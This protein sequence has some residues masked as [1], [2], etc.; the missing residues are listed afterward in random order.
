M[1]LA[2]DVGGTTLRLTL[3]EPAHGPRRF[4]AKADYRSAEFS[5]LQPAIA[6]FLADT[7]AKPTSACFSV[8]G[9]VAGGRAHLTNLGWE[10]DGAALARDCGLSRVDIVNDVACM[11][12]SLPHLQP[13]EFVTLNRGAAAPRAPL[14]VVAPGTGLGEAFLIWGP[15]GYLVCP[16]EGGHADFAPADL[17]QA[18]LWAFLQREHSHVSTERICSGSGL[19]A[20]YDFLRSRNPSAEPA[21]FRSALASVSDRAPLIVAAGCEE[22]SNNPLARQALQLFS[23]ALAAEAGN[24]ALKVLAIG[25]VFLAGGLPPRIMSFLR[26]EAFMRAFTNKGRF[27]SLLGATPV[28]VVTTNAALLGATIQG[29]EA[30]D[31]VL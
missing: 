17:L 15:K 1:L 31:E 6:A 11:A 29:L 24:L 13:N 18:E 8:A 3:V 23:D 26:D 22:G 28:H 10:L 9:P 25:G 21:E 4:A 5:S 2:G 16:S 20:L 12:R 7:A 30:M 14:A 19:P 27:A